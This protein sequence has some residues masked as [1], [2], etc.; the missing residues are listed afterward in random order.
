MCQK[1]RPLGDAI[2][3]VGAARRAAWVPL[4]SA[5]SEAA[6]RRRLH[7]AVGGGGTAGEPSSRAERATYD[8]RRCERTSPEARWGMTKRIHASALRRDVYRLLDQ[9]LETGE[10]VEIERR[11][12]VLR[13][14]TDPPK[15]KLA[16][17]VSRPEAISGDPGD[18]VDVE[19]SGSWRP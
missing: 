7:A 11:G 19:W 10:P 13:I 15:S 9:V 6:G 18:L 12:R 8:F 16:A 5:A 14:V 4:V 17:L 3:W 1:V 2:G